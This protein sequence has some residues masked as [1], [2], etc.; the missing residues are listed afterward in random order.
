MW[1][2][3]VSDA[4]LG[5]LGRIRSGSAIAYCA[6]FLRETRAALLTFRRCAKKAAVKRS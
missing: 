1:I 2:A 4:A 5:L 6:N 3:A